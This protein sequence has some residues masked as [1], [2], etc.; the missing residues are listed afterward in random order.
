MD[1]QKLIDNIKRLFGNGVSPKVLVVKEGVD[2]VSNFLSI[3]LGLM[4]YAIVI[5]LPIITAIDMVYLT[6]P[7]TRDK[8]PKKAVGDDTKVRFISKDAYTALNESE[9]TGGEKSA[10]SIY[11]R[12]RIKTYVIVGSLLVLLVTGLWNVVRDWCVGLSSTIV[13]WLMSI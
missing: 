8:F 1:V 6:M 11:L 13:A 3:F 10:V 4:V 7:A 2:A 9:W 12:K 5:W